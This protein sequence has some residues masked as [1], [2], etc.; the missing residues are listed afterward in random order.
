M[1][2]AALLVHVINVD[3]ALVW[4]QKAFPDATLY[5]IENTE[6][7]QL[8]PGNF[9]IEIVQSDTKV[10]SGKSGTVLYWL[11]PDL[12]SAVSNLTSLGAKLYRGPMKIE[13]DLSMCQ[14]EDPF[15]NLIGLR[16]K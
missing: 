16:G 6:Q 12:N 5:K 10:G 11:V 4:Y 1:K 9:C 2:P 15:G 3:A 14:L 8:Q 13:N 7:H